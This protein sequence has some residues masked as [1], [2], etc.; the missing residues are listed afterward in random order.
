[1]AGPRPTDPM[2]PHSLAPPG[3]P[4][5][6][7]SRTSCFI[8]SLETFR[9]WSQLQAWGAEEALGLRGILTA[10]LPGPRVSTHR[11]QTGRLEKAAPHLTSG[12]LRE[13]DQWALSPAPGPATW[14]PCGMDFQLPAG[15]AHRISP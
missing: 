3:P 14:T 13:H 11:E 6:T 12:A 10:P 1:M 2:E 9:Y 7:L 4:R 15:P 5:W 8:M